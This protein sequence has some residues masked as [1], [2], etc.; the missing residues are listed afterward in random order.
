MSDDAAVVRRLHEAWSRRES[1]IELFHP[2]VEWSTP[3]PGANVRG[4]DELLAFL[5]SFISAWS[6]YTNELE[7][8]R[9]LPDGRL[10]VLFHEH[11]RGRT[12]GAE[13]DLSP[14][15][16]VEIREGMIYRYAGMYRDEALREA[17]LA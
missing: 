15:A 5:R 11:G 4:R 12:S 6:E 14:G 10:L 9:T 13:T 8:I 17:G 16:I 7:E 2:E 3:H 1:G